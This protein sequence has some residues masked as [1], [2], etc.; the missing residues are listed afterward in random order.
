MDGL[1]K[2]HFKVNLSWA[3]SGRL[4]ATTGVEYE[5]GVVAIK[6]QI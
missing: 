3:L 1:S 2:Y 4:S 5:Y 6:C